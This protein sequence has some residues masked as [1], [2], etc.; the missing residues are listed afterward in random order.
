M[1]FTQLL[2]CTEK[3]IYWIIWVRRQVTHLG[4]P[5]KVAGM[6]YKLYYCFTTSS[7]NYYFIA[8]IRVTESFAPSLSVCHRNRQRSVL[9]DLFEKVR[10]EYF[11]EV[12][13]CGELVLYI[14]MAV[15]LP[16][17]LSLLLHVYIFQLPTYTIN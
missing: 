2:Y 8:N 11:N 16:G 1:S 14:G 4:S 6:Y 10:A 7:T 5:P 13:Q 17:I 9:L 12:W 3:R 15:T